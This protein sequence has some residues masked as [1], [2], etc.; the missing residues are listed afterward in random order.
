MNPA[1]RMVFLGHDA[2][3]LAVVSQPQTEDDIPLCRI[4]PHL[5]PLGSRKLIPGIGPTDGKSR[6]FE[7]Y[8]G[9]PRLR[10]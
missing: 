9:A 8:E 4:R 10:H 1:G 2:A 6:K 5:E 3:K 7:R